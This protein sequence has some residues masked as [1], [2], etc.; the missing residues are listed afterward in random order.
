MDG[1]FD[2]MGKKSGRMYD[3]HSRGGADTSKKS[4]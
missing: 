3:T 4:F 2:G 1:R